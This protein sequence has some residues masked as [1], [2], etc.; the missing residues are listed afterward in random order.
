MEPLLQ[1]QLGEAGRAGEER[2]ATSRLVEGI[3]ELVFGGHQRYRPLPRPLCIP[4]GAANQRRGGPRPGH[5]GARQR[6]GHGLQFTFEEDG[7]YEER[8]CRTHLRP[9]RDRGKEESVDHAAYLGMAG[10]IFI[11]AVRTDK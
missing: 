10:R 11:P 6:H 1:S 9:G 4:H 5:T 7:G 8:P 2:P 3:R